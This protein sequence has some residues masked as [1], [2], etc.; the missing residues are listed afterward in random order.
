M[1]IDTHIRPAMFKEIYHDKK[2]F[3]KRCN[4]MNYHLMSPADL[5]LLKKQLGLAEIEKAVLLPEDNSYS[6][7]TATITNEDIKLLVDLDPEL[8]VGFASVDPRNT[9]A[10]EKLSDALSQ[11]E[12]SGLYINTAR[13]HMSP[14]DERLVEL[15][16]ICKI[17]HKPII[18]HSGFSFEN[19]ALSKY[20][21]P[22]LFEEVLTSFPGLN[23]CFA[24]MGWPWTK[25]TEALLI[26]YPNAY[27]STAM[28]YTDGPYQIYKQELTQGL[29]EHWY[30]NIMDKVMFG[31]GSPRIRPVRSKRGIESLHL[32]PEVEQKIFHDN[33][34]RFLGLEE[35]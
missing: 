11:T 16:D 9:D 15:Y 31:S 24:H 7:G 18:F 5:S 23:I 32:P 29:G 4:E 17:H 12:F 6:S 3:E 19:Y 10:H 14:M 28:M 26:K 20:A 35:S 27:A 22:F 33:A 1:V 21:E 25:E 2:T 8:F 30:H 34:V 13:L